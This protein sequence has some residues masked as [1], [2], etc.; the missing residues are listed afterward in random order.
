MDEK[1]VGEIIEK[2]MSDTVFRGRLMEDPSSALASYGLSEEEFGRI[3]SAL[4]EKFQGTL[5]PRLSKR[6][7]GKFGSMSGPMGIDGAVE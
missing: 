1:K 7:M 4:D 2:A 5:E 3:T 6:R